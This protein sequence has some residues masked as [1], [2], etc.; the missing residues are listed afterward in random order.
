MPASAKERL[1]GALT[2]IAC[3]V[4]FFSV[5]VRQGVH[6]QG[7]GSL[8]K[9]YDL[10]S[11]FLPRYDWGSSELLSGRLPLWNPYEYGGLPFLATAQ[12]A[13]FY[14]P[15]ILL[16]GLLKT[17]TAYWLF[18]ELHYV[19]AALGFWLF[20]ER[21]G[22]GAIGAFVGTSTWIFNVL[23]LS[24]NYH[25]NRIA[26][27]AWIPF[28][29]LL[30]DRLGRREGKN[31][32]LLLA[33][34][35]ALQLS[36][37]YP[38]VTLDAACLVAL[39]AVTSWLVKDWEL[40]PW[41]SLPL[42]GA[43]FGLG[44]LVAAAQLG[45]L[46]E[47]ATHAKRSAMAEATIDQTPEL[48]RTEGE[49]ALFDIPIFFALALFGMTRRRAACATSGF[50]ACMTMMAGGWLVVR[51][52]PGFSMLRFPWMWYLLV[53]FFSA[54]AAAVGAEALLRTQT[55]A[56]WVQRGAAVA[57]TVLGIAWG[58]FC[59][60]R[61]FSGSRSPEPVVRGISLAISVDNQLA[62][63]LGL[64][65]SILLAL[66]CWFR[67][68]AQLLVLAPLVLFVISHQAS[69]P[70]RKTPAPVRRPSRLG[71]VASLLGEGTRPEGRV[72]SATDVTYGHVITD[73][74]PS[75]FGAEFSFLPARQRQIANTLGFRAL[76]G[77][78]DLTR[79][80]SAGGFLDAMDLQYVSL[81]TAYMH[82]LLPFGFDVVRVDEARGLALLENK[83]RMGPAWVNHAVRRVQ[84]SEEACGLVLGPDFDPRREV[85]LEAAPDAS[86]PAS[87]ILPAIRARVLRRES[88]TVVEYAAELTHPGLL[89]VSESAYPGWSVWI[90]GEPGKWLT[91]NCVQKAVEL[92]PGAHRVR[93]EYWPDSLR[94]GLLLS[95]IGITVLTGLF[96]VNRRRAAPE[97]IA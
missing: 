26:N 21:R 75:L 40:P 87:S 64:A 85:V 93:F 34:V 16:F 8:I 54:W 18:L 25:P 42:L 91:A 37:G 2:V 92:T 22:I 89:V 73:R 59:A 88:H 96:V 6:D 74:L 81:S 86:Y 56:L 13:V 38:E 61:L 94:W 47:A 84:S 43:A 19:L 44:G 5:F 36:A 48:L 1:I 23:V 58:G 35:V 79:L 28:I 55:K 62:A 80:G 32:F 15:K 9:S 95:A 30:T 49:I 29:F 65:A 82:E 51:S 12:P 4:L 69:F 53:G 27:L 97:R 57:A 31:A 11:Y 72:F 68:R 63:A 24:S 60:L 33:L 39:H 3:I 20:L 41:R 52:L 67:G 76:F 17:R 66:T 14:P 90:D 78:P 83:H 70:F 45:P 50:L 7:G 10:Q 46:L 71:E 77:G